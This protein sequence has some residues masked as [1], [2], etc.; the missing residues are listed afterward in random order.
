[1]VNIL[2]ALINVSEKAANIAR[3]FRQNEHLFS[4]LVQEKSTEESNPRFVHDY[5]TL[6]DVLIQETIR[7][8]IGVAVSIIILCMYVGKS[9]TYF[10]IVFLE[11]N[12]SSN[13]C[14]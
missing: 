12:L 5:K 8:D 10:S 4:L 11:H 14:V 13:L 9:R 2:E 6:A 7:Y 1:M 3:I